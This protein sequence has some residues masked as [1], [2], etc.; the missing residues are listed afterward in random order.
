M[1]TS[2]KWHI[3]ASSEEEYLTVWKVARNIHGRREIGYFKIPHTNSH[4]YIGPLLANELVCNRLAQILSLPVARTYVTN[5]NGRT[6]VLSLAKSNRKLISWNH[7]IEMRK[8]PSQVIVDQERLYKTFVFDAW[9]CNV[10]RSGKNIVVYSR[11]PKY[12]FYLIDH[13]LALLGAVQYENKPWRSTYWENIL[14]Y[15]D[16]YHPALLTYGKN[17]LRLA[18]SIEEIRNI[19]P[20]TIRTIVNKI[21]SHFLSKNDKMLMTRILLHRRRRLARIISHIS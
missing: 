5:I 17:Y 21:P 18:P 13:E 20:T 7:L 6:G 16:G 12:D 15:T 3:T 14:K 19:R 9:I 10:D 1:E 11:G 4:K 2:K 8:D